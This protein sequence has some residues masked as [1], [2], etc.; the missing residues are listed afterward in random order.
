MGRRRKSRGDD[1]SA[2][3]LYL[4]ILVTA[5]VAVLGALTDWFQSMSQG[6]YMPFWQRVMIIITL[7]LSLFALLLSIHNER[8]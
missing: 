4:S 6:A 3:I 1:G 5:L 2:L 8:R 7:L